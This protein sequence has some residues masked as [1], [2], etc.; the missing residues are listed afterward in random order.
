[1]PRSSRPKP[2]PDEAALYD[3][4]VKAL[5]RR[6]RSVAELKRMLRQRST[7]DAA[8][9]QI[10]RVV[11][12]LKE[13]RYLN[14][15]QYAQSFVSY[16]KENQKFGRIRV[17]SELKARGVHGE[18]IEHAIAAGFEGA[19]DEQA[20]RDYLAR[21]RVQKP[22]DDK[23]AA[24]IFRMLLRAGHSKRAALRVLNHWNVDDEMIAALETEETPE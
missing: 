16:R 21:K 20:A 2:L 10:E 12:R 3:Y 18:V 9:A 15:A 22:K 14:D 11:Q 13:Q 5:G 19:D 6:M 17:I 1:M 23:A 4:A 8:A 7:G 24:R